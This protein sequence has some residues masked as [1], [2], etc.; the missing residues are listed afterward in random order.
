M[1]N[2]IVTVGI[3]KNA[4]FRTALFAGIDRVNEFL[5]EENLD[6]SYEAVLVDDAKLSSSPSKVQDILFLDGGEDV[7]PSRYK[8][9]NKYSTFSNA[10]DKAEYKVIEHFYGFGK[11]LSGVCRGHQILNVFFGGSLYQDIRRDGVMNPR[12]LDSHRGGHKVRLKRLTKVMSKNKR[13]HV[14]S[15]FTGIN[16]FTVSSMH[17]QAVKKL[18]SGLGISLVFGSTKNSPHYI[19][20]G[21]ESANS[22][23]RGIQSHPEFNGY[24]KDGLIFSY[25]LHVDD[26]VDGILDPDFSAIEKKL[27][28]RNI[29]TTVPFD[30]EI[31]SHGQSS[32]GRVNSLGRELRSGLGREIIETVRRTGTRINTEPVLDSFSPEFSD[33]EFEE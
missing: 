15:R 22:R 11:K 30:V 7:N 8:E 25:L 21:I 3:W 9:E 1:S 2:K 18:G 13:G 26:F 6:L 33:D 28:E 17:H 5:K 19:I 4:P 16:P 31:M 10:R 20:E 29:K 32:T 27:K 24:S 12:H 14:L 23:V